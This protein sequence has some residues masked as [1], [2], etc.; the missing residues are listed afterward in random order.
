MPTPSASMRMI[1]VTPVHRAQES[2]RSVRLTSRQSLPSQST[3]ITTSDVSP[4]P[5]P[6][7]VFSPPLYACHCPG[8]CFARS[9]RVPTTLPADVDGRVIKAPLS[10]GGSDFAVTCVSM[11]N[12]HAIIFV[13]DLDAIDLVCV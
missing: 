9:S 3:P 13:D 2:R 1:T 6:V 5:P 10:V 4:P 12:P 8:P 11:G 7:Y